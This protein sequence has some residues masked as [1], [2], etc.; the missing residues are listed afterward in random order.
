MSI[1]VIHVGYPKTATTTLQNNL[2]DCHPGTL[3][4]GKPSNQHCSELKDICTALDQ[5]APEKH[6]MSQRLKKEF[7]LARQKGLVPVYSE[8]GIINHSARN[9]K[10]FSQQLFRF[11][12]T[13]KIIFTI[14]NQLEIMKSTYLVNDKQSGLRFDE[15]CLHHK[16][17]FVEKHNYYDI[18]QSFSDVFGAG[19]VGVFLQEE[20]KADP[21]LFARGI[22]RFMGLDEQEGIVLKQ[23]SPKHVRLTSRELNYLR[24]R[25]FFPGIRLSK[26][27]P[28]SASRY[29]ISF[30][31]SGPP[32][33]V[34][35]SA[36]IQRDFVH[37]FCEGNTKLDADRHLLLKK[38][39]YPYSF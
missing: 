24:I 16:Q 8:E 34:E 13:A 29:L 12:G 31:R 4:L 14:R 19:N 10:H 23:S 38:Y 30:I 6:P 28:L 9:P 32:A 35:L 21:V 33:N 7:T 26:M 3:N 17:D 39:N 27:L 22:C 1:P 2:F 5:D 20:L 15:W 25:Q 11:F 36:S 18:I 37:A